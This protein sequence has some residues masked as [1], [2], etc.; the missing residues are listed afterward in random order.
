MPH[1]KPA[2]RLIPGIITILFVIAF[3]G[4][5]SANWLGGITFNH[6]SPSYLPYGE[7]VVVSIDCKVTEA[8]GVRVYVLPYSGLNPTPGYGTS[9]SVIVPFGESTVSRYFTIN[10]GT[11]TV[12]RVR[13][14]MNTADNSAQILE[15]FVRVRYEY[16]PYG[17]FNIDLSEVDHSVL[18][19]GSDLNVTCDYVTPGPEDVIVFARPYTDGSLSPGYSAGGGVRVPFAGSAAQ[20]FTF[21]SSDSDV[22]HI[23]I[24]IRNDANTETLFEIFHPVD[25]SWR[26]VGITDFA[27]SV[28][29]PSMVHHSE[30][31]HVSFVCENGSGQ[32]VRVW[33]HPYE[34]GA[35]APN[36]AFQGSVAIGAGTSAQ[37]RYIGSTSRTRVN[38]AHLLVTGDNDGTVYV[39]KLIPVEYLFSPHVVTNITMDPESP[40]LLENDEWLTISYDYQTD[41]PTGLR[42]TALPFTRGEA[43]LGYGATGSALH[44][45]PSGSE[46]YGFHLFDWA[47]EPEVDQIQFQIFN[48]DFSVILEEY[49]VD[50]VHMWGSEGWVTPVPGVLSG[51]SVMLGQ[52]FPNPFNPATTIPVEL[53]ATHHVR[54]AV[55][56]L[57]GRLVRMVA[58]E[59]MAA[60]RHELPFDGSDLASGEYLLRLEGAGPP[61]T[62]PMMLVK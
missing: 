61:Q 17:I 34:D 49:Y 2:A 52:N 55:Y 27:F 24:Y 40:A 37:S 58:D 9:G 51:A 31:V 8:E 45:Y 53:G 62:R 47:A 46:T 39:D 18:A 23:R 22:D 13:V 19:N 21:N 43:N 32:D 38:Q 41:E 35:F 4:P 10:S 7:Q 57:R 59:M 16:G 1:H 42:V 6:P 56:D 20:H 28:P 15:F 60:G 26:T 54:L 25:F 12:D 30:N 11:P 33:L 36:G 3:S 14:R 48:S 44:A 50:T 5:A 29:S